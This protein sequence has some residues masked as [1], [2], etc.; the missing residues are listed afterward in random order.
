MVGVKSGPAYQLHG[1]LGSVLIKN[2]SLDPPT[3]LQSEEEWRSVCVH[4]YAEGSYSKIRR[5]G[6]GLV[7]TVDGHTDGLTY[8]YSAT[9]AYTI[10]TVLTVT[11]TQRQ[12]DVST[13]ALLNTQSSVSSPSWPIRRSGL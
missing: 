9:H 12:T 11:Q 7:K 5:K 6:F 1:M 13:H 8:S 2:L 3:T 4:A 10:L